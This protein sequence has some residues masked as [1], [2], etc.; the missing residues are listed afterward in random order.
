MNR[1]VEEYAKIIIKNYNNY[2]YIKKI[3]I[4][5]LLSLYKKTKQN[6]ICCNYLSMTNLAK[7]QE[8]ILGKASHIGLRSCIFL[9]SGGRE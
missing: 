1:R 6:I 5:F 4:L 7:S 3:K 2:V 9:S 8:A